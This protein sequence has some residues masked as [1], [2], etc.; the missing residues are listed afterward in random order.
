M[1]LRQVSQRLY[2]YMS[3][4]TVLHVRIFFNYY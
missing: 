1:F 4:K 3:V 2:V